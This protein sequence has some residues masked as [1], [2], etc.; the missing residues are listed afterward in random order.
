VDYNNKPFAEEW[1]ISLAWRTGVMKENGL[2]SSKYR[3]TDRILLFIAIV[4]GVSMNVCACGGSASWEEE[5]QLHDGRTIIVKR[6][7]YRGGRHEIGQEVPVAEHSVCFKM[8]D[9]GKR[10]TWSSKYGNNEE[11]LLPLAI[12]IVKGI[13]YLVT[14]PAGCIGYNKWDRPNPPY[15]FFK[16][17][18]TTWQRIPLKEFPT[19]V[20]DANVVISGLVK[21]FEQRLTGRF[22]PVPAEEIK[23]I[24]AEA[25]NPSVQYLR[26]FVRAPIKSP[27]TMECEKLIFYKGGWIMPNDPAARQIM[28]IRE[29]KNK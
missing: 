11:N 1:K 10:I 17:D 28:D 23:Q 12:D 9:T 13:P 14:T 24:N 6:S 27:Q 25:K 8:P 4:M 22:S 29:Q 15:V 7:Q 3:R 2:Q 26:I 19:E 21:V 5:A 20:K 18:G 16:Y